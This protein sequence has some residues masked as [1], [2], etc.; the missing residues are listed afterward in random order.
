M[1]KMNVKL[2]HFTP[3][4]IA[5]QAIRTAWASEG[6]SDR[7]YVTRCVCGNDDY[8]YQRSEEEWADEDIPFIYNIG[9]SNVIECQE[10]HREQN[11]TTIEP[12]PKDKALIYKVGNKFRHASTLEHINYNFDITGISRAL[13]QELARHRIASLTVKST[14]YTLKELKEE[15]PFDYPS[16][17]YS[18][19]KIQERAHKYLVFTDNPHVTRASI[20]ALEELR[21]LVASGAKNDVTKYALPE[22]YRT[23]LKWTVN[24][25]SLQ[26]FLSLRTDKGAL[27]EIQILAH[28]VFDSLPEDHKYLAEE[29]VK[30]M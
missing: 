20:H 14:R 19:F 29:F 15:I 2:L 30:E 5:S 1:D 17:S 24:L 13:L 8:E 16:N 3:L 21:A 26:N 10:C 9:D 25:R 28:K 4:N 11:V 6:A 12:G 27:K 7:E 23:G 18:R 22:S